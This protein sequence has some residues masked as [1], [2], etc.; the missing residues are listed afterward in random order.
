MGQAKGETFSKKLL[1]L[2]IL[3]WMPLKQVRELHNE[4]L[5]LTYQNTFIGNQFTTILGSNPAKH[6]MTHESIW[7]LWLDSL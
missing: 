6:F 1:E 5:P 4:G 7:S 3:Q 2:E